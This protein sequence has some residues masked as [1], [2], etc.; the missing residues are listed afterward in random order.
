MEI[1]TSLNLIALEARDFI[2]NNLK[3]CEVFLGINQV[4]VLDRITECPNHFYPHREK[5]LFDMK[6]LDVRRLFQFA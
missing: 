5:A 3:S 2:G 1:F 6:P 4:R